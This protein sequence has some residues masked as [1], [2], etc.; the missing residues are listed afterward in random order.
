M[1]APPPGLVPVGAAAGGSLLVDVVLLHP[2]LAGVVLSHLTPRDVTGLRASC[3]AAKAAV[4]AHPWDAPLPSPTDGASTVY[5]QYSNNPRSRAFTLVGRR[6]VARWRACFPAARC[7]AAAGTVHP[8]FSVPDDNMAMLAG[9]ARLGLLKCDAL[10]DAALVP[11]VPH[12]RELVVV[13]MPL[14]AAALARLT[15]LTRFVAV[16]CP[17]VTDALLGPLA[18][19]CTH[20]TL[21][22]GH[23]VTSE[24]VAAHLSQR[25]THLDLT[26]TPSALTGAAGLAR[27]TA[28]QS[29][30][31]R[32]R[33]PFGFDRARV[34]LPANALA[35]CRGTLASLTLDQ[36]AVAP[37]ALD[38]LAALRHADLSFARGGLTDASFAGCPGLESLRVSNCDGFTGG[39]ALPLLPRL[40]TLEIDAGYGDDSNFTGEGLGAERLPALTRLEVKQCP[41]WAAGA[42]L[43]RLP[44][45]AHVS[46]SNVP[47]LTDAHLAAAACAGALRLLTLSSC[48]SVSG[49]AGLAALTALT[50]LSVYGCR[51][52]DGAGLPSLPALE[53]L[54]VSHCAILDPTEAAPLLVALVASCPHLRRVS[55]SFDTKMHSDADDDDMVPALGAGWTLD[56][57]AHRRF[58]PNDVSWSV[59]RAKAADLSATPG[60]GADSVMGADGAPAAKRARREESSDEDSSDEDSSDE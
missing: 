51:R 31:V 27:C 26:L 58:L 7:A 43:A 25:V 4:T 54:S 1:D 45:L 37:A 17:D 49:G 42:S 36:V 5:R 16:K 18:R 53:D 33:A 60:A 44:S 8:D 23:A 38:G 48:R 13:E 15:R 19:C 21:R 24:G 9:V 56:V 50:K 20:V 35:G 41:R 46:I 10:T 39:T 28:L 55:V 22:E 34:E 12:L 40:A 29:L 14:S 11:H 32:L 30:A 3:R 59:N 57:S 47:S 52:F 6:Q 2:D